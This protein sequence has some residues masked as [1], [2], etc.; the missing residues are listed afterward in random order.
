MSH[1]TPE[2][3]EC[4]FWYKENE[5]YFR[6]VNTLHFLYIFK[7]IL[8]I[9]HYFSLYSN[10]SFCCKMKRE[11]PWQVSS[12][13]SKLVLIIS[14]LTVCFIFIINNIILFKKLL[15]F[16]IKVWKSNWQRALLQYLQIAI[17]FFLS[18]CVYL[19]TESW[20]VFVLFN[21]MLPCPPIICNLGLFFP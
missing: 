9:H 5:T 6:S 16:K 13:S 7:G 15:Q 21:H 20:L 2:K 1:F 10:E 19:H 17:S 18:S 12:W 4:I 11:L 14:A 8:K 3:L